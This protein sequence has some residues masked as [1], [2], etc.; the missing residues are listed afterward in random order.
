[1]VDCMALE[2]AGEHVSRGSLPL[3]YLCFINA[4]ILLV[5]PMLYSHLATL[6][7]FRRGRRVT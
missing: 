6:I 5:C 2:R 1:M 3:D 7:V 4:L